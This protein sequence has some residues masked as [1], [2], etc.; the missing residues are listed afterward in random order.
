MLAERPPQPP[1][2]LDL[3]EMF[4]TS[5][6]NCFTICSPKNEELWQQFKIPYRLRIKATGNDVTGEIVESDIFFNS[7]FSWSVATAGDV[8]GDG[9]SDVVVGACLYDNGQTNEGRAFV[10]LGSASG[11]AA[12][13][14]VEPSTRATVSAVLVQLSIPIAEPT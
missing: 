4:P 5:V 6:Y 10:Y 11:L 7:T 14:G 12:A 8:N 1:Q 2:R 9:F 13:P 3:Q